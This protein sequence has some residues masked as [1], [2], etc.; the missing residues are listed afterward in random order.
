MLTTLTG[1]IMLAVAYAGFREGLFTAFTMLVNVF[2][3]GLATFA[4]FEPLAQQLEGLVHGTFL[5]GYEDFLVMVALFALVLILLRT[6]CDNL[7]NHVVDYPIKLQQWG[8]AALGL[9]SGYIVSGV[10]ICAFQTLPWHE[11]FLG[12]EP[13]TDGEPPQRSF[14]PP[15]RAWLA[16]MR[17]GGAHSL[18]WKEVEPEA[19][20]P[21][22]RYRTFDAGASFE[23]RYA[24]YR[25]YG[26]NRPSLVYQGEPDLGR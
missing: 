4:F 25:R 9:A 7:A 16:L 1:I 13:R 6:A 2:L 26:D 10:L 20:T 24:R 14:M 3:A 19:T 23:L 12:F 17:Y 8:G 18:A 22:D 15:D 11:N 5:A 21:Y